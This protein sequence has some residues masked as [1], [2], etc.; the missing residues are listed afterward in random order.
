MNPGGTS[1]QG[2]GL[3]TWVSPSTLSRRRSGG[4]TDGRQCGDVIVRPWGGK[5]GISATTCDAGSLGHRLYK[6]PIVGTYRG[7]TPFGEFDEIECGHFCRAGVG[8]DS[9]DDPSHRVQRPGV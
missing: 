7:G 4:P 1:L 8:L 5:P 6:T 9:S 2:H 3:A